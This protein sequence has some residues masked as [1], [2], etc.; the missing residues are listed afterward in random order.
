M[1]IKGST[2]VVST[3][4]RASTK[5]KHTLH[6]LQ[7]G[8]ALFRQWPAVQTRQ[9]GDAVQGGVVDLHRR[10]WFR[11]AQGCLNGIEEVRRRKLSTSCLGPRPA[12]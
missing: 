10:R 9:F 5:S 1:K 7:H 11:F 2:P 4:F 6:V 3:P 8:F 12:V